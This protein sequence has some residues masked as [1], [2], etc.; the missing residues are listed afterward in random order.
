VLDVAHPAHAKVDALILLTGLDKDPGHAD[1]SRRPDDTD[2]RWKD[3]VDTWDK[4]IRSRA[5][6][7]HHDCVDMR[8]EI[9]ESA[10]GWG[11]FGIWFEVFKHDSDMCTRLIKAFPGTAADCFDNHLPVVRPGTTL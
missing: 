5:R 10:I 7:A 3:R 2:Q 11:C 1:K 4:A 8:E 6:L 9:V